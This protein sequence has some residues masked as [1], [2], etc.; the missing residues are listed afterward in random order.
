MYR[1]TGTLALALLLAACG[2]KGDLHLPE[3]DDDTAMD[4]APVSA[5]YGPQEPA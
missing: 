5:P 1:L 3:D 4:T 2:Q